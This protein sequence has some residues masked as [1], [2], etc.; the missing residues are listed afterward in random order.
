MSRGDSYSRVTGKPPVTSFRTP[1]IFVCESVG[2]KKAMSFSLWLEIRKSIACFLTNFWVVWYL[3]CMYLVLKINYTARLRCLNLNL[4]GTTNTHRPQGA[5]WEAYNLN[6]FLSRFLITRKVDG[7]FNGELFAYLMNLIA[8]PSSKTI[9]KIRHLTPKQIPSYTAEVMLPNQAVLA[10]EGCQ[11]S[12]CM[13]KWQTVIS[14]K[15][16]T[17]VKCQV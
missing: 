16:V 8:G 5:H 1:I 14:I 4:E 12:I 10:P 3:N 13:C 7:S 11:V 6:S 15:Q 2:K 17:W 9:C